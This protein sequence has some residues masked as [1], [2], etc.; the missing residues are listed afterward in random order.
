MI[1]SLIGVTTHRV[2]SLVKEVA[3][4][5]YSLQYS[6]KDIDCQK[7]LLGKNIVAIQSTDNQIEDIK[8]SLDMC[9]NKTIDLEN[10]SRRN[11]LRITEII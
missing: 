10:L 6:Q 1:E 8:T 5:K 9:C 7:I 11:N 2:D 4:L 3:D